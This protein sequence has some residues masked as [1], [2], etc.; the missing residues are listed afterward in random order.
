M[1][2]LHHK[3]HCLIQSCSF[4]I[5]I[6]M[7]LELG[8]VETSL[9][10][11]VRVGIHKLRGVAS[12]TVVMEGVGLILRLHVTRA[13]PLNTALV[14]LSGGAQVKVKLRADRP[15]MRLIKHV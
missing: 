4:V 12:Q 2:L 10:S 3:L 15:A 8:H 9:R 6:L 13:L 7:D 11:I 14:S 1:G 5:V